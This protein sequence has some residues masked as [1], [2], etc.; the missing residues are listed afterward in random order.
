MQKRFEVRAKGL[1]G[2]WYYGTYFEKLPYLPS[3]MGDMDYEKYKED[4]IHYIYYQQAS[5]WNLPYQDLK[6]VILPH[7]LGTCTGLAVNTAKGHKEY[8]YEGD[9]VKFNLELVAEYE[10]IWDE[11]T[12]RF[13]LICGNIDYI[14]LTV[15]LSKHLIKIGDKY[16]IC[17]L[18]ETVQ[19]TESNP[20]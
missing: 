5:D 8:L 11:D 14:P 7:T 1:N 20:Q 12:L 10:V 17:S 16:E 4:T 15:E 19:E 18:R 9:I 13:A 2:A 6:V 3:P